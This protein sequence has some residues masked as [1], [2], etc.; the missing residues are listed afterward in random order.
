MKTKDYRAYLKA[1]G[2]K[3]IPRNLRTVKQPGDKEI[4]WCRKAGEYVAV[5]HGEKRAA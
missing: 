5:V 2:R 3:P 4:V 1:V